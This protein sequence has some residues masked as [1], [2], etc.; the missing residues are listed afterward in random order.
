MVKAGETFHYFRED[1]GC[2]AAIFTDEET[3]AKFQITAELPPSAS[4]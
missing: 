2:C 4:P 3:G 1:E